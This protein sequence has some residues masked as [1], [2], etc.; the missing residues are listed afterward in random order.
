[1]NKWDLPVGTCVEYSLSWN[2]DV[3][4]FILERSALNIGLAYTVGPFPWSDPSV[5][6]G[7]VHGSRLIFP[8][9]INRVIEGE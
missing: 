7:T 3:Y 6:R 8:W 2:E 4:G 9:Q 1:M 5:V